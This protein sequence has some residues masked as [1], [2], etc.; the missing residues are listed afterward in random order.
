[1]CGIVGIVDA[2]NPIDINALCRARDALTHRG[3]DD[4]DVWT[5]AERGVGLAHR[6]LSIIDLSP[7]GRQP[8]V[9]ADGSLVLIF[10][11]E[12]YNFK[13][14]R[15][16]LQELGH[17]FCSTSDTEVILRAY[18]EWALDAIP[19][20]N[21]MFA[22]A[23]YDR[24]RGQLVLARDRFGEKPLYYTDT[25]TSF[26]FASEIKA[27]AAL[28]GIALRMDPDLLRP[29]LVFGHTPYPDTA[30]LGIGKLPPAHVLVIEPAVWR[31]RSYCYWDMAEVPAQVSGADLVDRLDAL[32]NESVRLRL[33][34]DVPVG[35]FLSGGVDSSLIAGVMSR[36]QAQVKTFSIG[37]AEGSYDE[38]PHARA[39]AD[40]LGCDHYEHYV[41]PR[42]ALDLLLDLPAIY[43][44]PFADSSAIPTYIVSRF[45]REHVKV[46]LTG[47]G[48]DELFGGYTT[49]PWFALL[50]PL[51]RVPGPMRRGLAGALAGMGAGRLKRHASLLGINE[52]W[53]LFLYLNERTIAKR[54]D[55]EKILIHPGGQ[56]LD[57]SM[58]CR[59]FQAVLPRGHMQAALYA[60]AQTYLVD[61][62]LTKV[63]RASMAV[64]LETR[65]PLLDPSIAEFA[66]SLPVRDKMGFWQVK[67]KKLLRTLLG[68]YVPLHVFARPKHGF[69][70]PLHAWFRGEMRW[71]LQE[72]LDP[73]RIEREGL[74]DAKFVR[75]VV[76]EHLS[77]RRDR[78]ALLWSL[79][80][81]QLWREKWKV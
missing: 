11:G 21:G 48:G 20:L 61:D 5:D 42:E 60:E 12:I 65:I 29:Y 17:S 35:A 19:R 24:R 52:P 74:F 77:G 2:K 38:A 73:G 8:M 1:M 49:Y 57:Q 43:D 39:V 27:L 33:V 47:D 28:P 62:I 32:V 16:Q 3:P 10:N 80:F 34:A 54:F 72:Y 4:A 78:E 26:A 40:H 44:E 25:G 51:L 53:D 15:G 81:W 68:R 59:K 18:E 13:A 7:K 70:V 79:V 6:R 55:V 22:L 23:L 37:F 58:F 69:A 9:S 36:L 76:D 56:A 45:A 14:L 64:S 41:T 63:D 75:A 66:M 71:L 46:A 31:T 67:K 30:F 50:G